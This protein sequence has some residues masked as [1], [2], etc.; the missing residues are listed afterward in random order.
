MFIRHMV[1]TYG[2][3]SAARGL[4]S[5]RRGSS[6]QAGSNGSRVPLPTLDA[7]VEFA[8]IVRKDW[9]RL[10]APACRNRLPMLVVQQVFSF[11]A[12]R[13]GLETVTAVLKRGG[14][15]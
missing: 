13:I 7:K 14:G 10:N 11:P 15:S 12:S 6:D 9:T 3:G 8:P 4:I 2:R 1:W 5:K